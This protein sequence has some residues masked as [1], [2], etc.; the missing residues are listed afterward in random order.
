[1]WL[2]VA[3]Y[4]RERTR[5]LVSDKTVTN[6]LPASGL[7]KSSY[8]NSIGLVSTRVIVFYGQRMGSWKMTYSQVCMNYMLSQ[9]QM[10]SLSRSTGHY[11][12]NWKMGETA[13]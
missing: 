7:S 5:S 3:A 11:Y 13:E 12:K 4:G 8:G 6:V 1:M 9:V 10:T 2:G